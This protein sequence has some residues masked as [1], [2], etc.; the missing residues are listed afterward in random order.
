MTTTYGNDLLFQSELSE[1][2]RKELQETITKMQSISSLFYRLAIQCGNHAF[3]EF[4]GL[5]NEYINMCQTT[6][7]SGKDFT[8][9]NVHTGQGLVIEEYQADYLG[10]KF[11]CIFTGSLKGDLLKIFLARLQSENASKH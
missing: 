3:I 7:D 2:R 11:S 10:E 6:L 5:M 9:C 1:E 4:C 8:M